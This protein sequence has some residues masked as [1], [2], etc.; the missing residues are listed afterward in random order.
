MKQNVS[1]REVWQ[2]IATRNWLSGEQ[3]T[4]NKQ[5]TQRCSVE[6][7]GLAQG[8]FRLRVTESNNLV[9]LLLFLWKISLH[10]AAVQALDPTAIWTHQSHHLQV[11]K[12]NECS[13]TLGNNRQT[14]EELWPWTAACI[15]WIS[16]GK[17]AHGFWLCSAHSAGYHEL[18]LNLVLWKHLCFLSC[19][20]INW[21][22]LWYG[23][24]LCTTEFHSDTAFFVSDCSWIFSSLLS[25]HCSPALLHPLSC[26]WSC[27]PGTPSD[28]QSQE[29][30]PLLCEQNWAPQQR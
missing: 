9:F 12:V 26:C 11:F 10:M 21:I 18:M 8:Q 27:A 2:T 5:V 4:R 16:E 15:T 17:Q 24:R 23:E 25:P 22:W 29:Q 14:S 6:R 1:F 7:W 13:P 3:H 19:L 20:N 28:E 30:Q